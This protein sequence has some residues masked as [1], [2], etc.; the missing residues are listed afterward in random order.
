MEPDPTSKIEMYS[1]K[2]IMDMLRELK[3]KFPASYKW[4]LI[5]ELEKMHGPRRSSEG[6]GEEKET[7]SG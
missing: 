7:H 6:L 5:W 3:E 4:F 1:Y 2:E